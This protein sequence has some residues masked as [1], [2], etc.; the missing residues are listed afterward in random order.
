MESRSNRGRRFPAEVLTPDEVQKL[1]VAA[2]RAPIVGARNQAL[3]AVL[4][5]AGL[6]HAEALDLFP[7]DVDLQ[8]GSVTVLNGKG[9]RRRM[10]G[11]DAGA[12]KIVERWSGRRREIGFGH[13]QRLFC[14]RRGRRLSSSYLRMLLPKLAREVGIAKRVHP[15]GLRHTHAYELMLEGV[16]MK[17]IQKQLGHVSLAT[18]DTYL[19][20]IAPADLIRAIGEREWSLEPA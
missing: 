8:L 18:T 13:D 15:H 1:L 20:H 14:S 17:I 12:S 2:G 11:I 6:R 3:L 9:G 4:Y 7:K 5:R 10:V 16:A 19:D